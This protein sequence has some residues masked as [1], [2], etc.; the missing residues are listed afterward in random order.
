[1]KQIKANQ[2]A[3]NTTPKQHL[4]DGASYG[5]LSYINLLFMHGA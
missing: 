4:W 3:K 1:M 2:R 5:K